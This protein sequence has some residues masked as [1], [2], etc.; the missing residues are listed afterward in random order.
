MLQYLSCGY[1]GA[2]GPVLFLPPKPRTLCAARVAC[3]RFPRVPTV[4][5]ARS[6][7]C[8]R[9]RSHALR[10]CEPSCP[11]CVWRTG[12]LSCRLRLRA[13]AVSLGQAPGPR[14]PASGPAVQGGR[15]HPPSADHR[16]PPREPAPADARDRRGRVELPHYGSVRE[17]R[18]ES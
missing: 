15:L 11:A 8:L 4:H 16:Q 18:Q 5:L 10:P 6:A 13:L 1:N 14:S 2:L 7:L 9:S 12:R 3:V 17:G